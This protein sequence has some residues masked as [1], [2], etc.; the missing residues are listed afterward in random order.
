[1][2]VREERDIVSPK[3]EEAEDT[4]RLYVQTHMIPAYYYSR[5]CRDSYDGIPRSAFLNHAD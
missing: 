5:K 3:K 1:M 2:S 4:V